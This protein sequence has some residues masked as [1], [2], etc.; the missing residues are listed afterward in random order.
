MSKRKETCP[1]KKFCDL[2]RNQLGFTLIEMMVVVALIGILATALLL[3]YVKSLE[4]SRISASEADAQSLKTATE[5]YDKFIGFYPPDFS[6]GWDPGLARALPYNPDTGESYNPL[7]DP[8]PEQTCPQCP[9]NWAG[10]IQ[11]RWDG[12]YI[13]RWPQS[14]PWKGKYDYN[15]WP[16]GASR[17]GCTVPGGIYIG[18]QGDYNNN[19]VLPRSAEQ[20]MI[21]QGQDADRCLNG[22]AQILLISLPE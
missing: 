16:D 6:R 10:I 17:Y 2:T 13:D 4:D 14:T 1:S 12:P 11:S 20:K 5:M 8:H 3:N 9:Q 15:Y 19:N 18:V 7:S 22:E 21:D